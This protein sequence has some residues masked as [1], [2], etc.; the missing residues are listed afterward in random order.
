[1][2]FVLNGCDQYY[3]M[4]LKFGLITQRLFGQFEYAD[5]KMLIWIQRF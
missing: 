2:V 3:Y 1:M 5:R 4:V